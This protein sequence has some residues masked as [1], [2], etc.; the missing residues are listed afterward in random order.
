MTA[1]QRLKELAGSWGDDIAFT[2]AQVLALASLVE[3]AETYAADLGSV[4]AG[5]VPSECE[6]LHAALSALEEALT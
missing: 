4:E 1:S 5:E 2:P 3:A 6:E